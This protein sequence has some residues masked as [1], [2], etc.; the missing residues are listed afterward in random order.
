VSTD[1]FKAEVY[2]FS[3]LGNRINNC[4][5][6]LLVNYSF[7]CHI[8]GYAVLLVNYRGSTGFGEKSLYSLLGKVGEQDVQEVHNATVQMI[9][10]HSEFL[11]N[12]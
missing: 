1:Q 9:E 7:F 12:S 2:F 3:Q 6:F 11:D 8:L 10:K 4:L 5:I